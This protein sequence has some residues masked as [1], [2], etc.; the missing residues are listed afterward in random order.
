MDTFLGDAGFL[1]KGHGAEY[2]AAR[3]QELLDAGAPEVAVDPDPANSR[4]IAAYKIA[5]FVPCDIRP[6]EDGDP[7]LVMHCTVPSLRSE[8]RAGVN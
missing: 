7:V 4:A 5:G 8:I 6:C 1:G 2:I 3:A